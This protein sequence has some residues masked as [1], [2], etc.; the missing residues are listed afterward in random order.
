MVKREVRIADDEDFPEGR[1]PQLAPVVGERLDVGHFVAG[2]SFIE[3]LAS[4]ASRV[5]AS[6]GALAISG[7]SS[8]MAR[9]TAD[10]IAPEELST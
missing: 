7:T 2:V 4:H 1:T 8:S 5:F 9:F 10:P 6:A 3:S